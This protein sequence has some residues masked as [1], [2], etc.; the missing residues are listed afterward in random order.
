M[1]EGALLPSGKGA[2]AAMLEFDVT[3]SWLP[4]FLGHVYVRALH[5]RL[6]R[7][8]EAFACPEVFLHW[9]VDA[10]GAASSRLLAQAASWE[11][12]A[13]LGSVYGWVELIEGAPAQRLNELRSLDRD[14]RPV[15]DPAT[16]STRRLPAST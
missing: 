12:A 16:R 4:Y 8:D 6:R 13:E 11:G 7:A 10:L 14:C 1:S 15:R 2:F 3:P 5:D 9:L